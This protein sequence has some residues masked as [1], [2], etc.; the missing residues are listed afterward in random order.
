MTTKMRKMYI[1]PWRHALPYLKANGEF[2]HTL[3]THTWGDLAPSLVRGLTAGMAANDN[4]HGVCTC[5]AVV[6]YYLLE[7]LTWDS[8]WLVAPDLDGVH[9]IVP[10]TPGWSKEQLFA[11]FLEGRL[12]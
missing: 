11:D 8:V 9:R 1:G 3:T 2:E 6:L 12:L 7:N 4:V 10:V 5:N